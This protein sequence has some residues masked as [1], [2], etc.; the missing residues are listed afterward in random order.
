MEAATSAF[1]VLVMKVFPGEA[2]GTLCSHAVTQ[3]L[4]QV[5]RRAAHHAHLL[6]SSGDELNESLSVV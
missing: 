3:S 2:E 5:S 4:A 1:L 6:L